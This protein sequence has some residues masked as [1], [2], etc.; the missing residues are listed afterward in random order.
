MLHIILNSMICF[1]RNADFKN[2]KSFITKK[3][4]EEQKAK[5][6]EAMAKHK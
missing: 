3:D 1:G 6:I 2:R 4:R 5:L